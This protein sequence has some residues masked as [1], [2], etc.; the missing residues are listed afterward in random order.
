[1]PSSESWAIVG[2]SIIIIILVWL[3]DSDTKRIEL[4]ELDRKHLEECLKEMSQEDEKKPECFGYVNE[5]K[6][7]LDR[8]GIRYETDCKTCQLLKDCIARY[9]SRVYDNWVDEWY[10]KTEDELEAEYYYSNPNFE[11][12]KNV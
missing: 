1:M 4:L 8:K 5:N 7:C 12:E 3:I 11:D 6:E 9:N 10:N 2:L